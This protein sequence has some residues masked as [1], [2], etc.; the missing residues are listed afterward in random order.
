MKPPP[1]QYHD[2]KTLAEAVSLLGTL[3][4]AK[5]LAGGQ[6]LV[7][8]LNFRL[9]APDI[10]IDI[11]RIPD[12]GNIGVSAEGLRI[13]ATA[14]WHDLE[15]SPLV[16][17]HN[18]LLAEAVR[19]VAHYQIRN[20]GTIG[21]SCAHADPA[22]E[23]PA[24]ALLCDASFIIASRAGERTVKADEFFVGALETALMSDE[25]LVAICFP[26]WPR[27]RRFAF[28]E[29]SRRRGDFAIAGVAALLDFEADG[30]CCN[31]AL[32]AFGIGDR[33]LRLSAAESELR[34]RMLSEDI[35][36]AAAA[37]AA[38]DCDAKSD[39]HAPAEYR[40]ALVD[41]LAQRALARAAAVSRRESA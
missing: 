4:N 18:P 34:D 39:M 7:P 37:L 21:G 16:A 33:A 27:G 6:S 38:Q 24:I 3:D 1:F 26:P 30:R 19:H 10:L 20:R 22:A 14:R 25:M 11:N 23:I 12:L 29:F 41:T 32:V 9:A 31:A 40:R 2:P 36:R 35:I 15:Q 13:G 5:L 8:M 28:E 17:S